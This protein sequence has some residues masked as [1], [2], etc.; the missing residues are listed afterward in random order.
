MR[1][2]CLFALTFAIVACRSTAE[3]ARADP[4]ASAPE[5]PLR[6]P[7]VIASG[8]DKPWNVL[9]DATH[10]YWA[11]KGRGASGAV[12]RSAK[13]GGVARSLTT[14]ELGELPAPYGIALLPAGRPVVSLASPTKG[15][16]VEVFADGAFLRSTRAGW[17][18][19]ASAPFSITEP[20]ALVTAGGRVFW[21]DLRERVVA[22]APFHPDLEGG[23]L[24]LAVATVHAHTTGRPVGLA[25][26]ATHVYWTDSDPGVVAKTPIA[27]G[28]ITNLVTGGD[29]T[30]GLAVDATHVYWSEWGSGRIGKV[31]KEGG[32]IVELATDQKGARTIAIGDARVYWTHPPSGSVR[33]VSKTGGPVLTHVTGQ[34]HPYSVAVDA[35]AIYWANVDGD[36]VMALD[37]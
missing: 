27:G 16:L 10:V 6:Q 7:R 3:P 31:P 13:A 14:S 30:T 19:D 23:S 20:W 8:Q 25:V 18:A 29:K 12:M 34:K 1:V 35:T 33:S 36:T 26:D 32:P 17:W 15:G 5:P 9:V 28:P 11:N 24:L 21:T 4:A 37:K 2:A 22:S